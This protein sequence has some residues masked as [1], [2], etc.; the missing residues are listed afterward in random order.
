M[1]ETLIQTLHDVNYQHNP[2]KDVR[3][4]SSFKKAARITST[5]IQPHQNIRRKSPPA[6]IQTLPARPPPSPPDEPLTPPY[7][8]PDIRDL[9]LYDLDTPLDDLFL[10]LPMASSLY[11]GYSKIFKKFKSW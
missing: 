3:I 6:Q 5:S 11:A 9:S 7:T 2:I 8:V 1:T 4:P 10:R